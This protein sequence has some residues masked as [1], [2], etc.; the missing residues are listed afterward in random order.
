VLRIA[1]RTRLVVPALVALLVGPGAAVAVAAPVPAVV[2]AAE[3]PVHLDWT[4]CGTGPQGSAAGVQ[5]AT[6][7]LPM[8]YDQPSGP[9]VHIAVA[10]VPAR[11]QAHRIGSLFF[12]FGGPG[13]SSVDFL[14]AGGA[15]DL[16]AS[17][18]ERFDIVGFDPRGVGQSSPA[19]DCRVDQETQGNASQP[20]PTPLTAEPAALVAKA[21]AYVRAC[22]TNGAILRHLSTADVARDMDALRAA[23]GDAQLSYLGF[24][25]G[26]FLGAT[27]AALFP[28]RYRALVLDGPVDAQA[29]LHDPSAYSLQQTAGFEDALQRFLTACA[30]DQV[31]CSAFGGADPARAYDDLLA[32]ADAAPIPA[33]NDTADPRPV[34]GDDVR[35]ATVSLLYSK[36]YWGTLA[37]ALEQAAT[38][39]ASILR[40]VVDLLF[41]GRQADGTYDPLADRFFT[42]SASEEQY[43]RS[44]GAALQRGAESWQRFPHF[45]WNSGYS[46]VA[47]ALWPFSDAD[48]YG[49]PW[50]LD[51]AA[52][53]PLV[54]ATTHDPATPYP[55]ALRLARELGNARLI[56]MAGDGHTAY[57]ANS[58]CINSA[59]EAYLTATALPAAGTVC[60]QQVPFAPPV[61][62]PT[63]AATATQVARTLAPH[64]ITGR[65][66]AGRYLA[67]RN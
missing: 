59:V 16:F 46:E 6:A 41:Y 3:V 58:P 7:V 50:T 51:A 66:L 53:P 52:P 23:V 67:G 60:Q 15:D 22:A 28:G 25:Y 54:V 29:Y 32:R 47:Y 19:V 42:I 8:D 38:G 48:A 34:T 64:A 20:F 24:S 1:R 17:L 62:A 10:R 26:T 30:A 61:P 13:A 12:D 65:Y 63:G 57:G 55:G 9:A 49:G 18:N 37:A 43:P 39:D 45:W 14:Q 56:T 21:Q 35:A 11:D 40:V 4:A 5:C 31:A 2:P 44:T 33:P 36:Q 27:Y